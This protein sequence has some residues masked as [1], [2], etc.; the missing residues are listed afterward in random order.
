MSIMK[1]SVSSIKQFKACRRAY[2]LR[3]VYRIIPTETSEALST[4][5]AYHSLI[6][7]I[8]SE[9]IIPE[10]VDKE[11]AMANAYAKY[12]LPQMPEFKPEM[13]FEKRISRGKIIV[14]RV[15]GLADK[16]IVEH[17]TTSANI[18]EYECNLDRD[19]QLLM[20][21]LAEGCNT[22]YY[23]ICKK[24]TIRQKQSETIEEF[25]KRCFEWYDEDTNDKI[26]M[27]KIH[28]TDEQIEQYRH[29]LVKMFQTIGSAHKNNN[30]YRNT[31]NCNAYG[32]LCEYAPICM[33]F[34]PTQ[35]Y[36]G[37]KRREI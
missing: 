28:R 9:G 3:C 18:E 34:D 32:R 4:G 29:E 24:P 5:S 21:F 27:V 26:R 22:A 7:D 17:K 31:C 1:L 36:V 35:E 15:D 23:T 8:H 6:E 2:E 25:A 10:I 20:Y 30:F 13:P 11:S 19:E 16:A 33:N 12:I 37:F 14:G